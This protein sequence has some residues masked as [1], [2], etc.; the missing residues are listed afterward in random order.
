MKSNW[1]VTVV[2]LGLAW[3]GVARAA[4][5]TPDLK[6]QIE[7]LRKRVMTLEQEK[8]ARQPVGGGV[9]DKVVDNKYG[10]NATVTT[11]QGKLT[12]GG[13]VQVWYRS[14]QNDNHNWVDQDRLAPGA[15]AATRFGSNETSDNDTFQIRRARLV[16]DMDIHENVS[17]RIMLNVANDYTS[18]PGSPSNQVPFTNAGWGTGGV[19]IGSTKNDA[20][21]N[22]TATAG[23][24]LE[25]A[26]INY[27]GVVPHHDFTIGQMFRRIGEEGP[28]SSAALDFIERAMIT[29]YVAPLCDLGLQAHGAWLDDRIQY[30]L[31]VFD[32][33]GSAFQAPWNR[34]DDNDDKDVLG[35]VQFRPVWKD[36]TWGSLE[37]GY[38]MMYGHGGESGGHRFGTA[39]VDGLNFPRTVHLYQFAW[40]AYLP[41][42]PVKGW[43]L[44]G[45][46]GQI[47][48]R[49]ASATVQSFVP[50]LGSVINPAPFDIQGWYLATGY[51]L[52]DSIF[53][54][55]LPNWFK[56][57]EFTFRYDTMQN[58][59]YSDLTYPSRRMDVFSTT[60][61]TAGVNYYLK[62]N[63]AKI[64][65]N[66]NWVREEAPDSGLRQVREVRNDNLMVN[67]QVAW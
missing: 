7:E 44:R 14:I 40:A 6:K 37:L 48:D 66:Y 62:G 63:H 1:T 55:G 15:G 3:S 52:S 32:H 29:Q 13:L 51:K 50:A 59:F 31:G 12:I 16:F 64:Q 24:E 57:C 30:W 61:Y 27:H 45:E 34:A 9:V 42:G 4:D 17:G 25:E 54:N 67:F 19:G 56:P 36:E 26:W 22:G 60:A 35:T 39:P 18:F 20:V 53:A 10:P 21:R 49:F 38:S 58:L 65:V 5:E 33:A 23:R 11:K 46:W 28:R 43:W 41:G 8:S 47:R 2:V